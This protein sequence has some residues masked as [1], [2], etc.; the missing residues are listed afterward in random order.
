MWPPRYVVAATVYPSSRNSRR[1]S[2]SKYS[3]FSSWSPEVPSACSNAWL[4]AVQDSPVKPSVSILTDRSPVEIPS[5]GM[6]AVTVLVKRFSIHEKRQA[7]RPAEGFNQID[8]RG[9]LSTR[10]PSPTSGRRSQLPVARRYNRWP[11]P[12]PAE[13]EHCTPEPVRPA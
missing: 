3:D 7:R 5:R 2:V 1:P 6:T 9:W 12:V 4:A 13:P 10:L 11:V 8:R